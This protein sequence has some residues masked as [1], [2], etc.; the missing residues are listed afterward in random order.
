M[1]ATVGGDCILAKGYGTG[2]PMDIKRGGFFA[3]SGLQL[4]AKAIICDK[5]FPFNNLRFS[6][7]F[8]ALRLFRPFPA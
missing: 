5:K 6:G 4:W 7:A 3:L 1:G 2:L 8:S